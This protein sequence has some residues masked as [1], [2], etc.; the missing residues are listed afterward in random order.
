MK[1]PIAPIAATAGRAR[2]DGI[3]P[4]QW[5]RG[6]LQPRLDAAAIAELRAALSK[7]HLLAHPGWP[8]AIAEDAS[9]A[10]RIAISTSRESA[11]P[12]WLI[13][14]AGSVL[15]LCADSGSAAAASC[16][17][18]FRAHYIAPDRCRPERRA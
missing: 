8:A 7:L 14:C 12:Q 17:R 10:I 4:L 3:P 1:K 2:F 11:S 15:L 9:A 5:W 16:L 13:D 6:K 18:L